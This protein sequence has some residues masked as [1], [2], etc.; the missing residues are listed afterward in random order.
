M[1]TNHGAGVAG[2]VAADSEAVAGTRTLDDFGVEAA[3]GSESEYAQGAVA[4]TDE[5][6][7]DFKTR[8]G[9]GELYAL[10][11]EGID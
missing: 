1:R 6:G 11:A 5:G 8:A 2:V 3:G 10:R 7:G 4:A 9:A